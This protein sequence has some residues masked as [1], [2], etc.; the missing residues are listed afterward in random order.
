MEVL[1]DRPRSLDPS[2]LRIEIVRT[3]VD[4]LTGQ[5][6]GRVDSIAR[7]RSGEGRDADLQRVV[8]GDVDHPVYVERVVVPI[9]DRARDAESIR[10][11]GGRNVNYSAAGRP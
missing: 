9:L 6:R 4:Q 8:D 7:M 10:G 11:A 5:K 2:T 1:A 3:P